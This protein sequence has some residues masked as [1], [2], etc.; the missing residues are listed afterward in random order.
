[1]TLS[2]TSVFFLKMISQFKIIPFD[3][4]FH[5]DERSVVGLFNFRKFSN[6]IWFL[7]TGMSIVE[8]AFVYAQLFTHSKSYIDNGLH[9][10]MLLHNLYVSGYTMVASLNIHI[11]LYKEKM[12]DF[13]NTFLQLNRELKRGKIPH[14]ALC[15]QLH[16]IR[17]ARSILG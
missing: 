9:S 8:C 4:R 10:E 1:M 13:T 7:V 15:A 16:I 12:A 3:W 11:Y 14:E 6:K 2:K 5:P 17:T